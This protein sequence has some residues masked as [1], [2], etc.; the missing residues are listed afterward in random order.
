MKISEIIITA[1]LVI[2][3]FVIGF[4]N[5][6]NTSPDLSNSPTNTTINIE[7]SA[8][9]EEQNLMVIKFD[10]EESEE[11]EMSVDSLVVDS[12]SQDTLLNIE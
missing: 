6:T 9:N 7:S 1:I 10:L 2:G 3:A 5:N 11:M 8:T 4:L 12:I